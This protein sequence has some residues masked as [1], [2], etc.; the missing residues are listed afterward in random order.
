MLKRTFIGFLLVYEAYGL[1]RV[2][3]RSLDLSKKLKELFW[4]CQIN[5]FCLT[6][7]SHSVS[8]LVLILL[9]KSAS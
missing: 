5:Y 1:D 2:A 3:T 6:G 8:S 7:E 4:T 9:Q